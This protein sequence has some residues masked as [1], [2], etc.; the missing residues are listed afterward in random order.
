MK[1]LDLRDEDHPVFKFLH[2]TDLRIN[3]SVAWLAECKTCHKQLLVGSSQV[4]RGT[5]NRCIFCQEKKTH[6]RR[7]I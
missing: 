6:D 3:G 2:P 1:S 5:H 4:K 7:V